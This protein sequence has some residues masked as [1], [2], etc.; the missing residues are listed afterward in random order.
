[1]WGLWALGI[2]I[3]ALVVPTLNIE[4]L[5]L[6][7]FSRTVYVR[8]RKCFVIDLVSKWCCDEFVNGVF[9]CQR[10][11]RVSLFFVSDCQELFSGGLFLPRNLTYVPTRHARSVI[12]VW[13]EPSS[14]CG[15]WSG[16]EL[17]LTTCSSGARQWRG[18]AVT[19]GWGHWGE[20]GP[21][22]VYVICTLKLIF[23]RVVYDHAS[24]MSPE[25]VICT[26][27]LEKKKV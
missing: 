17:R 14:V 8:I 3:R 9:L 27:H 22:M 26:S 16:C 12:A 20:W 11:L 2:S 6:L 25:R 15:S 18:L 23:L 13:Q 1:M 19:E 5:W 24:I 7:Y 10:F 21:R 4:T